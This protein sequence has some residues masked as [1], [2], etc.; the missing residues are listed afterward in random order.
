M[1]HVLAEERERDIR[2]EGES[3][4]NGG[5]CRVLLIFIH[6]IIWKSPSPVVNGNAD[7]TLSSFVNL[8]RET[9]DFIKHLT[10]V[11]GD[12]E[13]VTCG[14]DTT[15]DLR[16]N[17]AIFV[18]KIDSQRGSNVE[19]TTSDGYHGTTSLRTHP[20]ADIIEIW[21]LEKIFKIEKSSASHIEL[22]YYLICEERALSR[23]SEICE[24]NFHWMGPT[25]S[26]STCHTLKPGVGVDQEIINLSIC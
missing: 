10:A 4:R 7:H 19:I 24:V 25:S 21:H 2:C 15:G 3:W 14:C 6:Y 9:C 17:V 16:L 11:S 12:T 1:Q 26:D 13:F 20:R 18:V 22:Q 23:L 8:T 5:D